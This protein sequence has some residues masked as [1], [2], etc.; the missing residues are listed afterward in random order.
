MN[1]FEDAIKA[2]ALE[3]G[4]DACGIARAQAVSPEAA[5][6]YRQWIAQG[7]HFCMDYCARYLDVRDDPRLLL[8]GAQSLIV[9]A[10]NYY[11]A[12]FQP[13][14]APQFAYYA[15]GRDYH[16]VMRNRLKQLAAFVSENGGGATRCCVDTAPLRERYW[17][18]QA[19]IGFVGRNNTL[20]IPGRGS[21]FFIGTLL[22]TLALTP[23][24]PCTF[25]CGDC[26][27][28]INACPTAALPPINATAGEAAIS[29]A[30]DASRCLS[31]LT[32]EY[33]G[34]LPEW[35]RKALGNK[36]YGCD[37]CQQACPHNRDARPT[38]IPEFHPTPEFLAL[39]HEQLKTM[40]PT[41]F[42]TLFAHSPIRHPLKKP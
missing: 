22:T 27:A 39:T 30:V 2:R 32:I 28:C 17:A 3:L 8:E 26:G 41:T 34:E 20:I 38:T 37:E 21:Y 6:Q 5:Q 40:S 9:V 10:M 31:C 15:Y 23:D 4:L 1:N 42:A 24:E 19:G 12:V 13:D 7:G 29:G 25:T 33:R 35:A 16:K 14:D 18:Q 11:P 36:V